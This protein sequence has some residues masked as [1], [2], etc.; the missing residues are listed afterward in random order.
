MSSFFLAPK[1]HYL[2]TLRF[3]LIKSKVIDISETGD[4]LKVKCLIG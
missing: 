3:A 4:H 2:P 1:F